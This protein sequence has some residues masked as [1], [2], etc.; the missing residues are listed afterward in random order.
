[1][2]AFTPA[3][4]LVLG[5][6]RIVLVLVLVLVLGLFRLFRLTQRDFEMSF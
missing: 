2:V 1:M 5:F 4:V 3:L 6:F